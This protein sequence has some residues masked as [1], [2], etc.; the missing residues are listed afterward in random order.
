MTLRARWALGLAAVVVIVVIVIGFAANSAIRNE[1]R[2]EADEFLEERVALIERLTAAGDRRPVAPRGG[3]PGRVLAGQFAQFAQFD[4]V[5]QVVD[6]GGT[7]LVAEGRVVLPVNDAD[8][9]VAAGT[10]AT[11]L[12]DVIVDDVD[13][14]MIT[15]PFADGIALQIARDTTEAD[16]VLAGVRRRLVVAGLGGAALAAV[17]GWF[18]AGRAIRPV[19]QVTEAAEGVARTQ[20]LSEL[21]PVRG[22]DE[23]ARL[24]SSFNTMMAALNQS[25]RQQHQ[26]VMDASHELR[27]PLTSLRTS[28]E[29]LERGFPDGEAR[30]RLLANASSELRELTVLV[31]ELV[32]LATD[33]SLSEASRIEIDLAAVAERAAERGR[34]RYGRSVSVRADDPATVVVA[35]DAIDR[36]LNNLVDNAVKFSP[37]GSPIEVE[38]AGTQVTVRDHGPGI[39]PADLDL[40][41]ERFHRAATARTLPGSGLGLAIVRQIARDHDGDAFAA[42][43]DDGGA[44]VGFRLGPDATI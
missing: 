5:T 37:D 10:E 1:V 23:L 9:A 31:N 29:V 36:A 8:R 42:N 41:F 21:L 33:H 12:R 28:I 2:S 25:R 20:D 24:A 30:D 18:V 19:R 6:A 32:E 22:D 26:L 39:D 27:T 14:R 35:A 44:V 3:A 43:A 15:A 16:A 40:V 38:V 17:V 34:R 4:A 13:Y 7:I 11:I